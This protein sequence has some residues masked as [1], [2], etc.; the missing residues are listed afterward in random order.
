MKSEI[1]K[2][3]IAAVS[4]VAVMAQPLMLTSCKGKNKGAQKPADYGSF[5]SDIAREIAAK[6]PD[7]RAYS[8]GES[9]T[10]EYI[11]EKIK[12]L[13]YQPEVQSFQ[14]SGGSSN[15]YIV[16]IQGT[17]F[18]CARD[19]G[20][21]EL[22]HRIAVIG[23]HYDA[24]LLPEYIE[25]EEDDEDEYD[26][27]EDYD[28]EDDEEDG[29]E[30]DDEEEDDDS[31]ETSPV[32]YSFDGIS[33]N[34][35]G[36]AC[37]LTALM[38]YKD[39]TNV[40]YDVWFVF[41]GAGTDDFRGAAAFYDSLSQD[42]KNSLDVMYDVDS[43]YSGDKIYA[44]SGYQSLVPG[45]KYELRR[46]LYQ[47]YDVCFANTLYTNYGF[48]LY[49]NESGIKT[50]IDDDGDNEIFKEIPKNASDF[51]VFDD[52]MIPVVYFE[53]YEYNFTAMKQLKE[54]K[55]LS[56]QDFGGN[57]R[58]TP[59]D[60]SYFL[61]SVLIEEDYDRN[62]DG[63]IDCSG[64]RLQIRIN[65]VAFI[66]VESLLKG[67]DKGMTPSEY[68]AYRIEQTRQPYQSETAPAGQI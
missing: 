65:C 60:C 55:N 61:D 22:E 40:G 8:S 50:D 66:I 44:S 19:D 57:V 54:T 34:A 33:D 56:L 64:D 31:E 13:G 10:G 16:K 63:E 12:E 32:K 48:D 3:I 11:G 26:E 38:A 4:C 43:L 27:D 30:D 47:S 9:Q 25:E 5:G 68:E 53:S 15:N 49:Y 2:R 7:R 21:F 29:D 23:T 28:E 67:S 42:E 39:Y 51:K 20:S 17:G 35:S 46:K 52:K 1:V 41:F 59:A 6:F 58:R 62:G 24:A 45:K 37:I 36:T 14:G 18:Y